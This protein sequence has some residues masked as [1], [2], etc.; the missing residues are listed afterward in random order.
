MILYKRT[1]AEMSK[2]SSSSVAKL[3]TVKEPMQR[4]VHRAAE[5]LA[6]G[7]VFFIVTQ[8][9]RTADEQA[10]LYGKG[11]NAAEM[12]LKNL[13]ESYALPNEKKVTWTLNSN[14]LSG[15][16]VDLAPTVDGKLNWDEDGKLGLWK[17]LEK[18]MKDAAG[19]LET[20]I[21]WGGDWA[22]KNWDRP[23]FELKNK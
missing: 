5:L 6:G 12:R 3:S 8:G 22:G 9:L 13:P 14:H 4:V 7:K 15:S 16:A 20:P 1:E 2:L 21:V 11:R 19:E 17:V 23:H 18:A 10:K